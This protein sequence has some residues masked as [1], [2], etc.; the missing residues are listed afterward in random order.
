MGCSNVADH[1]TIANARTDSDAAHALNQAQTK[2]AADINAI[3]SRRYQKGLEA[4]ER[5][6]KTG[7]SL[8]PGERS[9]AGLVGEQIAAAAIADRMGL[10]LIH[11]DAGERGI[12]LMFID[13]NTDRLV[14]VEVKSG[15]NKNV[16]EKPSL[17][18]ITKTN[19]KGEKIIQMSDD[20]MGNPRLAKTGLENA[21][22]TDIDIK[23]VANLDLSSRQIQLYSVDEAG[24]L[25]KYGLTFD[26]SDY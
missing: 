23:L 19:E 21:A 14:A 13:L 5:A 10:Q 1:A 8:A 2:K 4:I 25:E 7:T 11:Q 3:L 17:G 15:L 24:N 20:W 12:D 6:K 26:V 16:G 18:K 9:A 22:A